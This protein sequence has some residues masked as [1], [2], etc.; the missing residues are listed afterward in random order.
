MKLIRRH[1]L[2]GILAVLAVAAAAALQLKGNNGP[3]YFTAKADRGSSADGRGHRH[4]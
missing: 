3:Q 4:H 2:I 1:W